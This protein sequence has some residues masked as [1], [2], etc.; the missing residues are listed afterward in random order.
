MMDTDITLSLPSDV[1][2][3]LRSHLGQDQG[4]TERLKVSLAIGLFAEQMLSLAKA[5]ALAG[6]DRRAFAY[7]LKSVGLP[8]YEYSET[9]FEEDIAFV[10]KATVHPPPR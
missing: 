7:L 5:A 3:V 8:A 9:D 6:M 10:R 4:V 2:A 1:A